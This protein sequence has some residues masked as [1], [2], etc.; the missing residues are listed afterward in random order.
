M[1]AQRRNM[2]GECLKALCNRPSKPAT[3]S[4]ENTLA[5]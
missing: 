3:L 1:A 5:L 2:G 4:L